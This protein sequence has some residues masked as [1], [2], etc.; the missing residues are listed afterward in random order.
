MLII[1]KIISNLILSPSLLIIILILIYLRGAK[2]AS[3]SRN[4]I[5]LIAVFIYLISIEPVKD[6]LVQPLEKTYTVIKKEQLR[7]ADAYIML[8]AGINENA[9][10][11]LNENG[12]ASQTAL[13]RLIE[14][15]RLYKKDRKKIFLSGGIVFDGEKSEAEIYAKF[16]IDL[17]VKKRDIII[18]GTSRTTSENAE[19]TKALLKKY[20]LDKPIL[21]TSASHMRRSVESFRRRGIDVIPAPCDY[22]SDYSPYN[23]RSFMPNVGNILSLN[24]AMWEYIGIIY[25][26]LKNK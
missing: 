16:L 1:Q 8:G 19:N 24:K 22:L 10:L 26:S 20:R 13:S 9:P 14:V 17:G 7:K 21:I 11:S 6:M 4:W 25:Y 15:V 2:T 12:I 18:E 3:K 23:F 5:P